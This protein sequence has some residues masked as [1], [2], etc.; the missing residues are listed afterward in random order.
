MAE[1]NYEYIKINCDTK[2]EYYALL[3][4][5]SEFNR[6]SFT[7]N[8]TSREKYEIIVENTEDMTQGNDNESKEE[9]YSESTD[10]NP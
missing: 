10:S 2:E 3:N 4:K 6:G 1:E 9:K 8:G 5:L 7:V